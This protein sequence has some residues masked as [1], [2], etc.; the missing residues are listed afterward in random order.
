MLSRILGGFVLILIGMF[1]YDSVKNGSPLP[2]YKGMRV[3]FW[4]TRKKPVKE[5]R[6]LYGIDKNKTP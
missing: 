4:N 2:R 1:I 5:I 6:N 3:D